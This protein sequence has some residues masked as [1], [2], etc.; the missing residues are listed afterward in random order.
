MIN[1]TGWKSVFKR[2][3]KGYFATPL[4]YIIIVIFL[5]TSGGLTVSRDYG[6]LLELR[7][8]SLQPFFAYLPLILMFLV[9][10][11]AMRLW[12]EER[13]SGT[14]ELLFTL[15]ITLQGSFIGKFLAGW[16]FLL[17]GLFLT[18]PVIWQVER[19]GS[20]DWGVILTGYFGAAL[21]AGTLL[22]IGMFFSALSKNQV[23]AF[24]LGVTVCIFFIMVVNL[25]QTL[26]LV[27]SV[28]VLGGYMEQVLSSLSITNHFETL[29][30]G[31]LELRTLVFF[32]LC[33][34]GWLFGGMMV[35]DQFKA[36]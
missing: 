30:R 26:E 3:F 11:V 36:S 22:S 13:K 10:A 1:F 28:P 6:R 18:F 27:G 29:T 15:P 7:Q 23:V 12:A 24:V 14:V 25:P 9:P 32:V 5:F 2:E 19:L 21:L 4:G 34:A 8:A 31:L 20:P 17:V 16:A 35:L 33:T